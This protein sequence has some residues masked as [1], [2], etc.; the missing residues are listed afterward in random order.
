MTSEPSAEDKIQDL[1]FALLKDSSELSHEIDSH[2]LKE[3]SAVIINAL[4]AIG[5]YPQY[6]FDVKTTDYKVSSL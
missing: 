2:R 6:S 1:E 4:I 5:L 3:N